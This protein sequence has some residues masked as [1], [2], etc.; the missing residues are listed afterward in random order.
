[1]DGMDA[2]KTSRW[3]GCRG[4]KPEMDVRTVLLDLFFPPKCA[5]CQKLLR[6]PRALMCHDCQRELPWLEGA[7]AEQCL[8]PIALCVSPLRYRE[9]VRKSVRQF[10]FAGK[11][12]YAKIYGVLMAQCVRDHLEGRYD[13]ISW[14]PVSRRRLR[15]RGYDQAYLLALE[16]ARNLGAQPAGLLKKRRDNPPQSGIE[17]DEKRRANVRDVYM[18]LDA[19]AVRGRRVLLVDDVVTTGSTLSACAKILLEAGAAQVLCLTLARAREWRLPAEK[20]SAVRH[21]DG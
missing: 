13:L 10:K 7:A 15:E 12:W 8:P 20:I 19:R 17:D 21:N 9:Q 2:E 1:M 6:E 11:R 3:T 5:F 14:V 16:T 4:W 18:L